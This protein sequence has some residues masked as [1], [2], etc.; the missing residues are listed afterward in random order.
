MNRIDLLDQVQRLLFDEA[1]ALDQ[2][3]WNDWLA[4]YTS[5]CEFRVPAWTGVRRAGPWFDVNVA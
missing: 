5:D 2:R 4:L 3:R 1:A